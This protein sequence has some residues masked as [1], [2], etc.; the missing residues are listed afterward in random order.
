MRWQ[1]WQN[2]RWKMKDVCMHAWPIAILESSE[3]CPWLTKWAKCGRLARVR[4]E[5]GERY[6]ATVL[7]VTLA[8]VL[9]LMM[10]RRA[11]PIGW[12]T[13]PYP[14]TSYHASVRLSV[15]LVHDHVNDRVHAGG[16]VE[17][18]VAQNVKFYDKKQDVTY[19]GL[20]TIAFCCQVKKQI[21]NRCN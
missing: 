1:R 21:G 13:R 11:A 17:E 18:Q 15:L 3:L 5:L 4:S 7:E 20:R 12:Q 14:R 9:L 2:T 10:T 19:N 16:K 8:V 6:H